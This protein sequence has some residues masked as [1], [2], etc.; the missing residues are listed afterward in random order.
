M[1]SILESYASL[2]PKICKVGRW[3]ATQPEDEQELYAKIRDTSSVNIEGL[4]NKLYPIHEMPFTSGTFRIHMN[5]KC[6]CKK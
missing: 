3:V 5:R 6:S 4:F 2:E 1:K